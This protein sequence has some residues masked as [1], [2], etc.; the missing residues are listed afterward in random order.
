M[1]FTVYGEPQG[2]ARPRFTKTGRAYTPKNTVDMEHKIGL[3][4]RANHGELLNDDYI[5][6]TVFAYYSIPKS[7]TK[8][9]RNL[10][11]H[12]LALPAKKPDADNVLKLV[13]DGLNG[14]A[15]KDDKQVISVEV[16]KMYSDNP[17]TVVYI[18]SWK[19]GEPEL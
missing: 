12:G 6:I 5:H 15:Y 2:K 18:D 14:V 13:M 8:K 19:K 17:R 7:A 10:I 4:Y 11:A 1:N 3:A 16:N 9:E